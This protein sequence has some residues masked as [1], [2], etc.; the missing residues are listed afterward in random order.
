[1]VPGGLGN[2]DVG[3]TTKK[4]KSRGGQKTWKKKCVPRRDGSKGNHEVDLV[5]SQES[6]HESSQENVEGNQKVRQ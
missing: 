6:D 4:K 5:L 3:L 1:M 2:D